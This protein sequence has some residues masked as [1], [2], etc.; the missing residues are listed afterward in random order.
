[1]SVSLSWLFRFTRFTKVTHRENWTHSAFASHQK[2]HRIV[3]HEITYI[4]THH[5]RI[6]E[7]LV[8]KATYDSRNKPPFRA[9]PCILP[10]NLQGESF[11]EHPYC[12]SRHLQGTK[13]KKQWLVSQLGE[14]HH[15]RCLL[16]ILVARIRSPN[17]IVVLCY[18]FTDWPSPKGD[19]ICILRCIEVGSLNLCHRFALRID[20]TLLDCIVYKCFGSLVMAKSKSIQKTNQTKW[21]LLK[22]SNS[23]N[24]P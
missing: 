12:P 6:A 15:M 7:L 11:T 3:T 21:Q 20:N 10:T 13:P 16:Q 18:S 5:S 24:K 2:R 1:M 17:P 19:D 4:I 8:P 22:H 23:K 9:K 14:K